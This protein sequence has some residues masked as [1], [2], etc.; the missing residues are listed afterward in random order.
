LRFVDIKRGRLH[1]FVPTT[2]ERETLEVGGKP[3]FIVPEAGGGLL[4]G[5]EHGVWRLEGGRLGPCVSAIDQ[6]IHNRTN[7][8]TVDSQ[9]RLWFGTMDD[10]EQQATGALYCLD[11]NGLNRMGGEAV[12]TNGPAISPDGTILYH[13]DSANRRIWRYTIVDGP[14]LGGGELFLQLTE[15]DGYPDGVTLD[16]EGCL[17]VALWDGWAVR[18]YGADGTLLMTVDL[19][20]ARVT[21]VALGGADLRTAYVTTARVGL[22]AVMLADQPL[23]GSLLAF[24]APAPGNP[25]AAA[26]LQA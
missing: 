26:F 25:L 9:G 4:V 17:W 22:D 19:P 2:G 12:V 18:R 21:K 5:S 20:C 3:S 23:A 6:P 14:A 15:A 11:A 8:G 13:V 1:R 16:S 24:E 7:D 10:A